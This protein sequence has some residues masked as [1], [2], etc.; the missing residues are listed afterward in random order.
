[1]LCVS[2]INEHEK[3]RKEKKVVEIKFVCDDWHEHAHKVG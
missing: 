3:E 2:H 1:M